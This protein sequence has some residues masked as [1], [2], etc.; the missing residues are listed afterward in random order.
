MK[1]NFILTLALLSFAFYNTQAQM[2]ILL[3]NDND[4]DPE[5]I[6]VIK[7]A[8]SNSGYTYAYWDA[9]AQMAGPSFEFM[10]PF[11]LVVWYTGNDGGS[12]YFWNGDET[13][14]QDLMNYIDNGGMLWVQGLDFLYDKYPTTPTTFLSG[15]F[16][17]DYLGILEYYGQSHIDDQI[18]FDGVPQ[19]DLVEGNGIFTLNPLKWAYETMWYVDA[20]TPA[21]GA[22]AVYQMGP[23]PI[24]DLWEYY[25]GIYF[26][27]G[28][29]KVLTFT[30]ETAR[31]DTP[32]NTEFLFGEA[33]VYFEQFAT[34]GILVEEINVSSEGDVTTIDEN[35]GTLQFYAEVLPEDAA[36]QSIFW[37][38]TGDDVVVSISQ[39]G[40]LQSSGTD[41]GNGTVWVKAEA[42]DGSGVS[43]VM[44]V[45]ISGQGTEFTVLLVN[46]NANGTDRYLVI[47]TTLANLGVIYNVYNTVVTGEYPDFNT[48]DGYDAVI[49]YTGNDG[50]ELKLWDVSDT[51]PGAVNQNLRFN[52]PLMQYINGGGIVTLQGLDFIFD[53]YGG[54]FDVFEPGDFIYDF[55]G[56][57]AYVAQTYVDGD[58]L[59]QLDVVVGN[60]ITSF[61]PVK[62]AYA[63]G[64][65]YA[66][67]LDKTDEA[68]AIYTMGPSNYIYSDYYGGLYTTPGDGH[69]F[70]LSVE[71]ARIDTRANTDAFFEAILEYFETLVPNNAVNEIQAKD[72][73]VYQNSPNPASNQT[74]FLWELQKP[75]NVELA[76]FDISGRKVFEMD[77]GTQ[78]T[79]KHSYQFS[80]NQMNLTDGLY[81]Y[82]LMVDKQA[83]SQ[84]MIIKK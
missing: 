80:A 69:L 50:V 27:K 19:L 58:P 53:I 66:D 79:G 32:E 24:Y 68:E 15:E 51:V 78:Q 54:A 10:N 84:K 49:W 1:R 62:W 71:T 47:D 25:S 5:R 8:I 12:L 72:F 14:N 48:L 59:P 20:L 36:I 64:L 21:E 35:F 39:D 82:S 42:M 41:N 40:L 44:E 4:Y 83:I 34:P 17:Y 70:T 74:T 56:I 6:E 43:D 63:E 18:S 16:V 76:I 75:S 57:S 73:T 13:E 38:V 22:Q 9:P 45:E 65:Y 60:P 26:E 55:M 46:D 7:A 11:D 33:L 28:D 3:V 23:V 81:T 52:A 37:S 30:F 61:T 77:F 2:S 31:I 29:G 67:V